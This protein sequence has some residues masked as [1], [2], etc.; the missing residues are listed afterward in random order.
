MRSLKDPYQD[1]MSEKYSDWVQQPL[2]KI[3][4][5]VPF[6]DCNTANFS[7]SQTEWQLLFPLG[8]FVLNS[9]QNK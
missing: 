6:L 5:N 1:F 7:L 9:L 3:T 2:R 4:E 8:S